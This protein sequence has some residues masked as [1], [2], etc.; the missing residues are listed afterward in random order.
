VLKVVLAHS[1]AHEGLGHAQIAAAAFPSGH[2]TASMSIAFAAVLVAPM[3]WRPIVAIAGALF[4]LAVSESI[5]LL[6]WHFPSDIVGGYLVA[7]SFACV[8]VAALRAADNRWPARSGRDAAKRAL[9]GPALARTMIVAL[10]LAMGAVIG[11]A[12]GAGDR[13]LD[14]AAGHTTVTIA[15]L[16]VAAMAATLPAAVAA[17]SLRR[18]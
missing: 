7:T 14:F 6:A 3:M 1:R 16:S 8:A 9:A 12:I 15:G 2:A 5:L 11:V 18:P 10:L 4:A 17:L 13:A